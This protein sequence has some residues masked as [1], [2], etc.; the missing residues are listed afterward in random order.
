MAPPLML[1]LSKALTSL[2]ITKPVP[3]EPPPVGAAVA[4]VTKPSELN[5]DALLEATERDAPDVPV[6]SE[7]CPA[8]IVD[9]SGPP[10]VPVILSTASRTSWT[11]PVVRLMTPPLDEVLVL[12]LVTK[13]IV[14]PLMVRVSLV[15]KGEVSESVPEAPVSNVEPVIGAAGEAWFNATAP[16][17]EL[18]PKGTAGVP[19]TTGLFAP[20]SAGLRPPAAVIDPEAAVGLA[21]VTG[22]VGRFA[23]Y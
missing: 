4:V 7:I 14:L 17:T 16:V 8:V 6:C 9:A 3:A 21:S 20:K 23:A 22:T 18:S 13:V 2:P 19:A 10:I 1:S 15:V 11:V 12:P 5:A